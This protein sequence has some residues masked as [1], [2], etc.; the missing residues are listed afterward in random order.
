MSEQMCQRNSLQLL[1]NCYTST[2]NIDE[3]NSLITRPPSKDASFRTR[4]YGAWQSLTTT[5]FPFEFRMILDNPYA[6][7]TMF[8]MKLDNYFLRG[9]NNMFFALFGAVDQVKLKHTFYDVQRY[10]TVKMVDVLLS[11]HHY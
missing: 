10:R 4:Q 9:E 8:L 2:T 7:K 5:K 11:C 6:S 3:G 1:S